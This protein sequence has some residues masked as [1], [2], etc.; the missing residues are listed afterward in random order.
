MRNI[1]CWRI[2]KYSVLWSLRSAKFL[3]V[4]WKRP[5][6]K[7]LSCRSTEDKFAWP[8][9]DLICLASGQG[10]KSIPWHFLSKI[11]TFMYCH[12]W[13]PILKLFVPGQWRKLWAGGGGDSS[14]IFAQKIFAPKKKMIIDGWVGRE[15]WCV[16]VVVEWGGGTSGRFLAQKILPLKSKWFFPRHPARG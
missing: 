13:I 4:P 12:D 1:K 7:K 5:W 10:L 11:L 14:R 15:G 9:I 3:S 6:T 2:M 16:G 8:R